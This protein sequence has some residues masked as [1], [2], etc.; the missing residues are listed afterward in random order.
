MADD[1]IK[2]VVTD[3]ALTDAQLAKTV[4]IALPPWKITLIRC[5][6]VYLQALVGFMI[7]SG[8]G[9]AA[10]IGVTMPVGSFVQLLVVSASMAVAPAAI[11]LI[12]NVIELLAKIDETVPTIRA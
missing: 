1:S 3:R 11:S 8:T 10:A 5:A 4:I 9:A 12:Q 7:A 2:T 6:R